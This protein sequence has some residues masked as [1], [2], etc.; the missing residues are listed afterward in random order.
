MVQ[1]FYRSQWKDADHFQK[2]DDLHNKDDDGVG[3]D[4]GDGDDDERMQTT[5]RR[6]LDRV[7]SFLIPP[8]GKVSI[9]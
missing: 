6:T 7:R 9:T 4:D 8:L 5:F 2:D 1:F 3:D